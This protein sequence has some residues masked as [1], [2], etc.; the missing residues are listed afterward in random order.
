MVSKSNYQSKPRLYSVIH[1]TIYTSI[2][3]VSTVCCKLLNVV[4][5]IFPLFF[6]LTYLLA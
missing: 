3:L 4:S 6:F 1:A 2:F 5:E